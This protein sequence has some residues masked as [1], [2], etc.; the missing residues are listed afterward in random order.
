M[1]YDLFEKL[2]D[3]NEGGPAMPSGVQ[4]TLQ[5]VLSSVKSA[6]FLG[7]RD[8]GEQEWEVHIRNQGKIPPR[9]LDD[10][11]VTQLGFEKESSSGYFRTDNTGIMTS[12]YFS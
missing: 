10:I 6:Q 4:K 8:L 2:K 5:T 12:I 3:I 1:W 11:M 9:S 7:A